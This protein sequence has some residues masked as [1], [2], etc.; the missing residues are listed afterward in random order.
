MLLVRD[1]VFQNIKAVCDGL[2]LSSLRNAFVQ[3][4]LCNFYVCM[5]RLSKNITTL[6]HSMLQYIVK[7]YLA[8]MLHNVYLNIVNCIEY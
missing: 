1:L 7:Y 6:S 4:I 5:G 8:V 2:I 3:H